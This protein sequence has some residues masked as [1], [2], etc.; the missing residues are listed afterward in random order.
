MHFTPVMLQYLLA[1]CLIVLSIG[2][3]RSTADDLKSQVN[4]PSK[5]LSTTTTKK[6]SPPQSEPD[7]EKTSHGSADEQPEDSAATEKDGSST[8]KNTPPTK[9]Q[10]APSLDELLLFFPAKHPAGNWQPRG[11]EFEDV[12]FTAD[13]ETRLHGWY[14]P[15]P[16]ARAVVLYAHGNAGN[17]SHRSG[18]LARLQH[19][20]RVAVLIFDYRGYG[21]SAGV[22]TVAGML[23][24]ARAARKFLAQH[25]NVKQSDIVMMGRSLGGAVAVQL[26]AEAKPRGLV[27]ESTFSSLRD[28][29][30]HHYPKLAWLVPPAKLDSAAMIPKYHGPLLQSHGDGDRTIPFASGMELF[31]SANEPKSF[32]TLPGRDHNAPQTREYYERLDQFITDLPGG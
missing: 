11:L 30:S 23:K 17:L 28:M 25:A 10:P 32:V 29:A 20:L 12:W 21:R 5:S 3:G 27:L 2:C 13:D 8:P 7:Q 24:D 14:C 4:P 15:C 6:P 9:T 1:V 31:R 19:Q 16:Q 26:A 18:L 22:P